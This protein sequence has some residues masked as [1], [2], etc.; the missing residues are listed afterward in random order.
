MQTYSATD[1]DA[2]TAAERIDLFQTLGAAAYG[3][4]HFHSKFARD[5]G[6][7]R[8]TF[9]NWNTGES[10]I[11]TGALLLLQEWS[12]R[13]TTPEVLLAAV[14]EVTRDLEKIARTLKNAGALVAEDLREQRKA[15]RFRAEELT[16]PE[17]AAD[18]PAPADDGPGI[19][20]SRL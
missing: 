18:D 12:G 8:R 2:M 15:N 10:P 14:L 6:W 17:P 11:P 13:R 19:D 7:A 16:A 5:S 9:Y 4:P 20:L 3:T 1:L